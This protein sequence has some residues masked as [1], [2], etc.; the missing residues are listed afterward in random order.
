MRA[1]ESLA[2]PF[3][4]VVRVLDGTGEALGRSGGHSKKKE[5]KKAA[6]HD[7]L[8]STRLRELLQERR[9]AVQT[10]LSTAG[11]AG[12]AVEQRNPA[13][14]FAGGAAGGT[15]ALAAAGTTALAAEVRRAALLADVEG[16]RQ[17]ALRLPVC[18]GGRAL[19]VE[20]GQGGVEAALR[21]EGIF[22]EL[23]EG[24]GGMQRKVAA[25]A[26]TAR[27]GLR[28]LSLLAR[29]AAELSRRVRPFPP[30]HS[31]GRLF[32]GALEALADASRPPPPAPALCVG[33]CVRLVCLTSAHGAPLN[34]SVGEAVVIARDCPRSA[35]R[36]PRV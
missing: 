26:G 32:L 1:E 28:S 14:S 13:D 5:A 18:D 35:E 16:L 15:T 11:A 7:A 30:R 22:E 2:S 17:F 4:C 20:L 36:A 21:G 27:L 10:S 8:S 25:V 24:E 12:G 34:G 33:D 29:K 3:W 6:Y 19:G 31:A 23:G 9:A